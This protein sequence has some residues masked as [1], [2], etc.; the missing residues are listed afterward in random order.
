MPKHSHEA[1]VIQDLPKLL[2][3]CYGARALCHHT[4]WL[5]RRSY[6]SIPWRPFLVLGRLSERLQVVGRSSTS[7]HRSRRPESDMRTR[8][9]K[10]LVLQVAGLTDAELDEYL[11]QHNL[12]RRRPSL[13]ESSSSGSK[14]AM[15]RRRLWQR[16][17]SF[18]AI[19][20]PEWRHL[21]RQISVR[22]GLQRVSGQC[23]V[24]KHSEAAL[25]RETARRE[26]IRQI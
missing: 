14:A 3:I 11:E 12:Q 19:T 22:A 4:P 1:C 15:I 20:R 10:P 21:R 8:T 7:L 2:D 13:P 17:C 6:H 25:P 18:I 5:A 16:N 24:S 26:Q 9:Q 23:H